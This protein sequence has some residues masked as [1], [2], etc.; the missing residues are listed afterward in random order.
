MIIYKHTVNTVYLVEGVLVKVMW[1]E[2]TAQM[3]RCCPLLVNASLGF[4]LIL[5]SA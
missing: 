4:T 3:S 1:E 2:L 5:F